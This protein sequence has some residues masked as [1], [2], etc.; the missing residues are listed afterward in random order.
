MARSR[1]ILAVVGLVAVCGLAALAALGP[2]VRA[3]AEKAAQAYGFGIEIANVRPVWLGLK[4]G[5]VRV[6]DNE[7]RLL[8][9]R[10]EE[11]RVS[12]SSGG[13]IEWVAI[14][15]GEV[16]L[17]GELEVLRDWIRAR[18]PSKT[19]RGPSAS[20]VQRRISVSGLGLRWLGVFGK[21]T[22]LRIDGLS[23]ERHA[24]QSAVGVD[25]ATFVTGRGAVKADGFSLVAANDEAG[26]S[27]IREIR[28]SRIEFDVGFNSGAGGVD[29]ETAVHADGTSTISNW[30]TRIAAHRM[31]AIELA[32]SLSK[33]LSSAGFIESSQVFAR[34]RHGDQEVELGPG[35]FRVHREGGAILIDASAG[36]QGRSPL[37]LRASVPIE[38]GEIAL[39]IEGGPVSLASLGARDGE[40]GLVGVDGATLDARAEVS[41]SSDGSLVSF[42]AEGH[43]ASLGIHDRR[44]AEDVIIGLDL[45]WRARGDM[46]SDGSVVRM[47]EG[48]LRLGQIRFLF[49][50]ELERGPDFKRARGTWEMP[51]TL[52]QAMLGSVPRALIP[53]T[54]DMQLGGTFAM[55]GRLGFDTRD[56]EALELDWRVREACRITS[57][58]ES[59]SVARFRR[60]FRRL[61]YDGQGNRIEVL[62]GPGTPHWAAIE[63]LSPYLEAAVLTTED[64]RFHRHSGFDKEAIKSSV[65]DNLKAGR[66]VRGAST[67]SMQLAKNLY[68]DRQKTLSRKLEEV[69]LTAYLEQA[70]TKDDILELYFNIVELGPMIYGIGQA[71]EHYFNT[72]P[73]QLSLGQAL[74]LVSTL[75]NPKRQYF[76]ADGRVT[77]RWS[78]YL[79]RLM[80]I[81]V[82]RHRITEREL[83]EGMSEIVT[84]GMAVSP[85]REDMLFET[86]GTEGEAESIWP[87]PDSSL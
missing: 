50:G 56:L 81:M 83:L 8:E 36:E 67:I 29:D 47:Q 14:A 17:R 87:P 11:I 18:R 38:P 37:E 25:A 52:C 49:E 43:L 40:L 76:D 54:A 21:G 79:H 58:P 2:L 9:A 19:E 51:S 71:S 82:T 33:V 7:A 73:S 41:L 84:R 6:A 61:A 57:V 44:L 31:R 45:G 69:L 10:F 63:D 78:R 66:F 39:K 30:A 68:L 72:T 22:S 53:R 46:R 24:G 75:P 3:R 59:Y 55:T 65:K 23:G 77:E 32:N 12:M 16:T 64:G 5:D 13:A 1:L 86:T 42:D 80:R 15:G 74:Y 34:V 70:L 62:S 60:P 4:L 27:R 35:Q 20:T 28:A 85:R 26:S 48:E